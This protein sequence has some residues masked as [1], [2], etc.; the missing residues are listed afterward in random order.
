MILEDILEKIDQLEQRISV[1]E[2]EK[3]VKR[4]RNV[5]YLASLQ[6]EKKNFIDSKPELREDIFT[7]VELV[8]WISYLLVKTKYREKIDSW[9]EIGKRRAKIKS[10]LEFFRLSRNDAESRIVAKDYFEYIISIIDEVLFN[11]E[12][13]NVFYVITSDWALTTYSHNVKDWKIEK[14]LKDV[15]L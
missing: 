7:D 1:L 6:S 12:K 13:G 8:F 3:L 15:P 10:V 5:D 9:S 2:T 14:Q 11:K 4:K